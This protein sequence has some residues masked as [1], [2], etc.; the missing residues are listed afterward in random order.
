MKRPCACGCGQPVTSR[1][2][3]AIFIHN[4]HSRRPLA[5]R[6]WA[7]VD[8]TDSCWIWT[9]GTDRKGYGV[10]NAPGAYSTRAAH[11]I[12]YMLTVGEIAAG[13]DLDHLCRVPACV[14][15][16]HLEPVTRRENV[17][18]GVGVSAQR[19][20]QTHC[21]RGHEFTPENTR[22]SK[23]RPGSRSCRTCRRLLRAAN[24]AAA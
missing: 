11:R 3:S 7:K 16:E 1:K 22:V 18:R 6:F 2:R 17:L 8:K 19:A 23:T 15:P 21:K 4:H 24:R 10:F 9:A 14:N 20:R 13:M 12:A 5:E